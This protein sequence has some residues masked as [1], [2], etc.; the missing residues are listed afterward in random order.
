MRPFLA[1]F[2]VALG[3]APSP[4]SAQISVIASKN[5]LS[6]AEAAGAYLLAKAFHLDATFIISTGRTYGVPVYSMPPALI[7]ARDCHCPLTKVLVLRKQGLGWGV[8]AHRL[9][10]PPQ[11]FHNPHYKL[12]RMPDAVIYESAWRPILISNRLSSVQINALRNRGLSWQELAAG[13][14][15]AREWN[16]T[17]KEVLTV[18]RTDRDWGV[19]GTKMGR[20]KGPKSEP[21][22]KARKA[23]EGHSGG[24][25]K[26]KGHDKGKGHG[27]GGG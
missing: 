8:I 10:V 22:G 9:G 1:L 6:L 12:E 16:R 7:I 20:G 3:F 17:P 15:F 25:G 11:S 27:K 2:F 18:Y 21:P 14:G 19:V 5:N 23:G 4:S 26:G 13:T 24:N